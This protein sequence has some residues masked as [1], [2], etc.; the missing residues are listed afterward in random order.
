MRADAFSRRSLLG[1]LAVAVVAVAVVAVVAAA[2]L[3]GLAGPA[4]AS[5]FAPV[6]PRGGVAL[7]TGAR[8][9]GRLAPGTELRVTVALRARHAAALAAY[10]ASVSRAGTPDY[11]RYLT[12]A[13]FARRFGP[14]ASQLRTVRAALRAPG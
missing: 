14:T 10:A 1:L 6:I 12:V 7:P 2:A 9:L 11:H 4:R 3:P 8:D 5:A 13:Q